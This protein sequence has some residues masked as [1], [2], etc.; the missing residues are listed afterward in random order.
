MLS[1][2]IY[3]NGK[4]HMC[5]IIVKRSMCSQSGKFS[6][7]SLTPMKF[8]YVVAQKQSEFPFQFHAKPGTAKNPPIFFYPSLFSLTENFLKI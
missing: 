8:K 6:E 4:H 7:Y 2:R 5:I 1:K 3:K